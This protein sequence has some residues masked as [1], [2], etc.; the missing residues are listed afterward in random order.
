MVSGTGGK[1]FAKGELMGV[2]LAA[3]ATAL[4]LSAGA[5]LGLGLS[6]DQIVQQLR[7]QGYGE[8]TISRTFLGRT[9]IVAIGALGRR[10]IIIDPRN[11]VILRD[12]Y[13]D[14][15]NVA[16]R[17][18]FVLEDD[19][20]KGAKATNAS[21]DDDASDDSAD[22]SEEEQEDEQEDEHEEEDEREDEE[23][24]ESEDED[25]H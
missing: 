2:R 19:S 11:G 14:A 8:I 17:G 7:N 15:N 4:M 22:D 6:A 12:L 13:I 24:D 5:A 1:L 3:L 18:R 25:D 10:E 16:A 9:R 23:E 21:S 20:E